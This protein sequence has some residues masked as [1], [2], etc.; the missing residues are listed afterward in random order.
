MA[1]NHFFFTASN[2]INSL[3]RGLESFAKHML[4]EQLLCAQQS[5]YNILLLV[6]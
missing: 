5:V 2:N 6:N 4:D 1:D 3:P